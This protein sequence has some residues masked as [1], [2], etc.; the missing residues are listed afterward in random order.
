[1][2]CTGAS[3]I[4]TDGLGGE[5]LITD[6]YGGK[7]FDEG[8]DSGDEFGTYRVY[9]RHATYLTTMRVRVP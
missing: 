2:I 1:M 7:L 4:V 8:E 5:L 3:F 9:L 6:G